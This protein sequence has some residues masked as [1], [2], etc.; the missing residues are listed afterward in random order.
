MQIEGPQL[1]KSHGDEAHPITDGKELE[2]HRNLQRN[3]QDSS[4]QL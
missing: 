1:E 4:I 2:A 3:N